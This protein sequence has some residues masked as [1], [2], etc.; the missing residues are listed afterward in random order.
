MLGRADKIIK[1]QKTGLNLVLDDFGIYV[2]F[3]ASIS[4]LSEME[5]QILMICSY[6]I[7]QAEPVLDKNPSKLHSSVDRLRILEE[8]IEFEQIYQEHK[9][10]LVESYMECFDHTSDLLEQQRLV[11]VIVDE[12]AR[13]PR[14]NL[15]ATHF[16]DSY[17]VE[18]DCIKQK[19][20]LVRAIID[21]LKEAEYKENNS[22]R[23]LLEKT[24]RVLN[25][26]MDK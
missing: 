18:I 20:S 14:L 1:H 3:D 15:K 24:Y 22:T 26:Q 23:E 2:L 4:D 16:R 12:M 21:I 19:Y 13:R 6:Y 10:T 17:R 8:A 5:E 25:D 11:Q 7:N 9:L